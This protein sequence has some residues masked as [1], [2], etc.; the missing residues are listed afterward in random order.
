MESTR[1]APQRHQNG[2]S[3]RAPTLM[4][5]L[6]PLDVELD[7]PTMKRRSLHGASTTFLS[8]FAKFGLQFAAQIVLAR[9]L[10]PAQYGLV[11]L[12]APILGFVQT[13]NDLGL[14]QAI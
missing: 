14:G 2:S 10:D 13:L 6:N 3:G 9:L 4:A 1:N 11:A 8:Q 7:L 5:P 12:A